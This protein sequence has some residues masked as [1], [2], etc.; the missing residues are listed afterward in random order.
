MIA[1]LLSFK[2]RELDS[3]VDMV[4]DMLKKGN[5]ANWS[6]E[7]A[8][9]VLEVVENGNID[10]PYGKSGPEKLGFPNRSASTDR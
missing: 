4:K 9:V 7:A 1:A 2:N 10:L 3:S 6:L 5:N 8:K